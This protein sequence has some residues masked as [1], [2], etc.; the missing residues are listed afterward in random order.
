M[1]CRDVA[2]RVSSCKQPEHTQSQRCETERWLQEVIHRPQMLWDHKQED[3]CQ[4]HESSGLPRCCCA[5]QSLI[6]VLLLFQANFIP[7]PRREQL[8]KL[9]LRLSHSASLITGERF[10]VSSASQT[11]VQCSPSVFLLPTSDTAKITSSISN[12]A[13]ANKAFN[14][15]SLFTC[16]ITSGVYLSVTKSIKIWFNEGLMQFMCLCLPNFIFA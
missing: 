10:K 9:K 5:C 11:S 1:N 8:A 15:G 12:A 3:F 13:L 7:T 2:P 6:K 4:T 16:V 14:K